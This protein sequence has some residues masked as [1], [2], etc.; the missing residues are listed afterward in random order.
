[1]FRF[2]G[3][4][5]LL[6]SSLFFLAACGA[7]ADGGGAEQPEQQQETT[8]ENVQNIVQEGGHVIWIH[9][10]DPI[11]M[12]PVRTSDAPSTHVTSQIME[13]L[14]RFDPTVPNVVL[15]PLL[16]E[17]FGRLDDYT[18]Y[19]NLRQGVY[20]HDGAYFNADV[21]ALN[22]ERI[23][24]PEI[25]APQ[26]FL[27]D[28]MNEVIIIDDYT[29]H[30]TTD[31]PFGPFAGHLAHRIAFMVS[32]YAIAEEEAGGALIADNPIGTGPFQYVRRVVGNYIHL[33]RFDGY[34]GSLALP[35]SV[36]FRAIPEAA[37]RFSMLEAGDAH[38]GVG[39]PADY[40]ISQAIPQMDT[41]LIESTQ[42][43]F[44]GFNT[45]PDHPYLSD[46]RVR[47]AITMAIN[48]PDIIEYLAEG[49]GA[50]PGSLISPLVEFSPPDATTLGYDP[51]A[52]RELL[53]EAG[54]GDGF[55]LEFFTN[56]GNSFRE[57]VGV[58]LQGALAPLNI[59]VNISIIPWAAYIEMIDDGLHDLFMLGWVTTTG[60][61]DYALFPLLHSSQHGSLGNRVFYS[62]P[63]VD[64]LLERGR[65]EEDSIERAAIYAEIVDIVNYEAPY[66]LIRFVEQLFLTNGIDGLDV[67]FS[68]TPWFQNVTLR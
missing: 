22:F 36:E 24:D 14:V 48:V 66:V 53:I 25:N 49:F 38:G 12:D 45:S 58:F 63:V 27:V 33:E 26:Q 10:S 56:E 52:A 64:Q 2:K 67:D 13:G 57:Q 54:F 59:N 34:W 17:S 20:F 19:F 16:A 39:M 8:Q 18:W 15:E 40:L 61:A 43:D 30:I 23:F 28:M 44:I 3:S 29:V 37:T 7:A 55:T 41:I 47:Q 68:N 51:E 60:D 32:P 4:K 42:V 6:F 46:I 31:F 1:M 35:D 50:L 62:N 11:S 21:V 9:P 5:V 65:I